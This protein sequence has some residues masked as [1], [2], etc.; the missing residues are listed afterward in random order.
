[1]KISREKSAELA[2]LYQFELSED[3]L[4]ELDLDCEQL[5]EGMKRLSE[6]NT[7][8]IEPMVLPFEDETFYLREG[9]LI[10]Q[11]SQEEVLANSPLT[12]DSYF[13]VSK[14]VE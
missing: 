1:M 11:L 13:V 14:V 8:N 9:D 7:D 10:D 12:K 3:E 4:R 6:V 2:K 5:T